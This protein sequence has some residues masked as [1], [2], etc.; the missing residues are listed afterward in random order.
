MTPAQIA[1]LEELIKAVQ[2]AE[3]AVDRAHEDLDAGLIGEEECNAS[4]AR[5][6]NARDALIEFVADIFGLTPVI[7]LMPDGQAIVRSFETDGLGLL[8][9]D[10]VIKLGA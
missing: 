10:R 7:I 8:P 9:P 1:R 2:V 4:A 6:G 5:E 3:T